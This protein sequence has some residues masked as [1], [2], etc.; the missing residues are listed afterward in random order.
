MSIFKVSTARQHSQ[1]ISLPERCATLVNYDDIQYTYNI[2][3]L[4]NPLKAV[5]QG[6]LLIEYSLL[7]ENTTNQRSFNYFK[8]KTSLEIVSNLRKI[9]GLIKDNLS[10]TNTDPSITIPLSNNQIFDISSY[11]SNAEISQLRRGILPIRSAQRIVTK[12]VA[13]LNAQNNNVALLLSTT[14]ILV[15]LEDME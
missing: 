12:S 9:S 3:I 11:I 4:V 15:Y 1:V 7:N 6:A 13:T 5:Q 2:N 10:V 14:T 8:N